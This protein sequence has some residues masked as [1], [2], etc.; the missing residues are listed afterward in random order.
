MKDNVLHKICYRGIALCLKLVEIRYRI[1]VEWRGEEQSLISPIGSA[2]EIP[3]AMAFTWCVA[4][5]KSTWYILIIKTCSSGSTPCCSF[6]VSTQK[7]TKN[8]QVKVEHFYYVF[9]IHVQLYSHQHVLLS[10]TNGLRKLCTDRIF[11]KRKRFQTA[12]NNT[13]YN[14]IIDCGSLERSHWALSLQ[15]LTFK[16]SKNSQRKKIFIFSTVLSL[17]ARALLRT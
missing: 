9:P 14:S 8:V 11:F 17:N 16:N 15:P 13:Y 7:Y 4:L 12:V 1:Y 3:I 2:S 6:P 10:R 5:K